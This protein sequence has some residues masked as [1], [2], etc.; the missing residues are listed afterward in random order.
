MAFDEKKYYYF[1][2]Y[3]LSIDEDEES[4]IQQH[5]ELIRLVWSKFDK[6]PYFNYAGFT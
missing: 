2:R 6:S 4:I 5:F 1:A 3:G